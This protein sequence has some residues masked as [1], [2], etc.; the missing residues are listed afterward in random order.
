[1]PPLLRG[2][3]W[4]LDWFTPREV[5]HLPWRERERL[6][7][8]AA[9]VVCRHLRYWLMGRLLLSLFCPPMGLAT[10]GW[11]WESPRSFVS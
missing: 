10:L 1:M 6:I 11:R 7:Q 5:R 8:K 4:G 3:F 2:R 9:D